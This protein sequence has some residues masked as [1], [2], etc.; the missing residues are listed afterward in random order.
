MITELDSLLYQAE[1]E[2]LEQ[3]ELDNF[4]SQIFA[5][6]KRLQLYEIISSKEADLFQYVASQLSTSYPDEPEA[7][8][9][10]ALKHWLITMRYCGMSMLFDNPKYLEHRVLEWLPE[11]IA[12][13]QL[14]DI[15]QSLFAVLQK[16]LKK[17]LSSEQFS[18]IQPYLE[19]AQGALL[20]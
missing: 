4:K 12:A 18:L 14:K 3:K 2:Y 15:E 6:E 11:Q 1:A 17:I 9:K 8:I 19:Q 10:R 16:R 5:L 7:K 20:S 13:H